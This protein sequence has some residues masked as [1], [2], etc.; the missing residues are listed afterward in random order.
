M[1][2]LLA[3][4]S[5]SFCA[6]Q[7]LVTC[8][9]GNYFV[10]PSNILSPY[11]YIFYHSVCCKMC[12][13]PLLIMEAKKGFSTLNHLIYEWPSSVNSMEHC[14]IWFCCCCC[15]CCC[16]FNL[17]HSPQEY[18]SS[19]FWSYFEI[20]QA[21]LQDGLNIT[22]QCCSPSIIGDALVFTNHFILWTLFL[23]CSIK[24]QC[25][26]S[27]IGCK[28]SMYLNWSLC[29]SLFPMTMLTLLALMDCHQY[30]LLLL[31]NSTP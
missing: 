28:F 9:T 2:C 27:I 21:L 23:A 16:P 20:V 4:T 29:L 31:Y 6:S 18:Y 25:C 17:Q 1:P 7:S 8:H 12:Q 22:L 24:F 26:S 5:M 11:L 3:L 15:C 14:F 30:S 13:F 10:S 19:F